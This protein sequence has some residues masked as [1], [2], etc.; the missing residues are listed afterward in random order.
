MS[1]FLIYFET[2]EKGTFSKISVLSIPPHLTPVWRFSRAEDV[3][4]AWKPAVSWNYLG[5]LSG[6]LWIYWWWSR[7]QGAVKFS[8][9]M[10]DRQFWG[11]SRS[12]F[13]KPA[14]AS[15]VCSLAFISKLCSY[16]K[17]RWI[18]AHS[19]CQWHAISKNFKSNLER[20]HLDSHLCSQALY[21]AGW[22][23]C[24]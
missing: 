22:K 21:K 19:L 7:E 24:V 8:C 10:N 23:M 13:M 5:A 2:S 15:S 3:W 20:D 16:L 14:A 18:V 4:N 1:R 11:D 6:A 9:G 17:Q 12:P